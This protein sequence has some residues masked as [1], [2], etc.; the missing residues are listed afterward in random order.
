MEI[1]LATKRKL[2][3]VQGRIA[4]PVDDQIKGDQ[5]DAC[6]NLVIAW[7]MNSVSDSIA[8]SILYT[9]SAFAIWKHL[10][11]SFAISNGSTGNTSLTEMCI[12]SNRMEIL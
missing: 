7:V 1:T 10:E 12:I 4:R 8:E 9:K 5:W 3:F 2:S 11:K 6:N